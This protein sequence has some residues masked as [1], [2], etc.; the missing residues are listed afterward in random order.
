MAKNQKIVKAQNLRVFSSALDLMWTL[1]KQQRDGN[2][3]TN[4]MCKYSIYIVMK[5]F[6]GQITMKLYLQSIP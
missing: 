4:W 6:E 5:V 2:N 1:E 3:V